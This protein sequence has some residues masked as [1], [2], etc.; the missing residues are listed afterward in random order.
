MPIIDSF[1]SHLNNILMKIKS[2]T[3]LWLKRWIFY[4]VIYFIIVIPIHLILSRLGFLYTNLDSAR[5]MLSALVQSE[6][7]ILG[8]VITLSLIVMQL[9]AQSYSIRIADLINKNSHDFII[10]ISI[11]GVAIFYGL[12]VLKLIGDFNLKNFEPYINIAYYFGIFAFFALKPYIDNTINIIKPST[13][14]NLLSKEIT[15]DKIL[16]SFNEKQGKSVDKNPVQPIIDMLRSSLMRYDYETVRE[17]LKVI[18]DRTN[19]IF[20]N[21]ILNRENE[22]KI[23]K[24]IFDHLIRLG[25]LTVR[26]EDEDSIVEII[27]N[28][29]KIGETTAKKKFENATFKAIISL[30]VIGILSAEKNLEWPTIEAANSLGNIGKVAAAQSLKLDA[31][32]ATMSLEMI[33]NLAYKHNLAD[34]EFWK[35]QSIE[36]INKALNKIEI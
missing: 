15:S 7:A 13:I 6:A 25:K 10:L 31:E 27:V 22:E 3:P 23:S 9:A 29:S 16:T 14:F 18:G 20:E 19:Y 35:K 5:Y 1:K 21:E 11:Y 28:I 12:I 8:I 34:V 36:K 4:L 33:G 26:M 32:Q 17:G 24:Y 30:R 2:K